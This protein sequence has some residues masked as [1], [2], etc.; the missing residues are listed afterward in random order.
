[1][2]LPFL[3]TAVAVAC[4]SPNV[5]E[6]IDAGPDGSGDDG[7]F[8]FEG[9]PPPGDATPNDTATSV[10]FVDA[11]VNGA[12]TGADG[13]PFTLGDVRVCVLDKSKS[14]FL[15]N[16]PQPYDAPMPLTNY[17]G[18]RQGSGIDLGSLPANLQLDIY[19]TAGLEN[20]A[21]WA[22]TTSRDCGSINCNTTGPQC[23]PHVSIPVALNIGVNV[24]ALVDDPNPDGGVGVK[25]VQA[26]FID[27]PF[28]GGPNTLWG[29]VV[30][31]SGWHAG[32]TLSAF[33]GA[34][35][36][37]GDG[38]TIPFLSP[39]QI[40]DDITGQFEDHGIRFEAPVQQDFFGQ[41]LDSIA[42]VANP[43]ITPPEF[44]GVRESF[45]L[46]LVGD[47]NDATSVNK[48]GGRD[49][50]FDRKGLHIAAIPYGPPHETP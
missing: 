11:L 8:G 32:S 7:G 6:R 12:A 33:Y 5:N 50:Q 3:V 22:P 40:K 31:F 47:P 18:I 9:A 20:D 26:S 30:D 1:L 44:Y 35:A 39:A 41:S 43:A 37:Q 13:N 10:V 49:P 15:T 28:G 36:V 25:L 29:S 42:Y 14:T 38:P 48:V 46:A 16:F 17:P 24:I 45:V 21:A 23:V 27:N 4:A 19:T 34:P 2:R